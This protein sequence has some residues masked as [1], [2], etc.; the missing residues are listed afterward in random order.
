MNRTVRTV[1]IVSRSAVVVAIA[2]TTYIISPCIHEA[3]VP[4]YDYNKILTKTDSLIEISDRYVDSGK[5]DSA[6][7]ILGPI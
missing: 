2:I 7:Y 1:K 5:Y 3:N 6:D 4:P